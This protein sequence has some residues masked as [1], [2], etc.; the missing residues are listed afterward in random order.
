MNNTNNHSN[1]C[2]IIIWK[3][4]GAI[5]Y[6]TWVLRAL[7]STRRGSS[8]AG[9][10]KTKTPQGSSHLGS[11]LHAQTRSQRFGGTAGRACLRRDV[12]GWRCLALPTHHAFRIIK[13][14]AKAKPKQRKIPACLLTAGDSGAL[15]VAAWCVFLCAGAMGAPGMLSMAPFF[16]DG[17]NHPSHD[18]FLAPFFAH[19]RPRRPLPP[20]LRQSDR[21]SK[22][23]HNATQRQKQ[24]WMRD[25]RRRAGHYSCLM[26]RAVK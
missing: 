24:V 12:V 4:Y 3:I 16:G 25:R 13:N 18:F 17:P 20:S 22:I 10:S 7:N 5:D 23:D 15:F 19:P 14:Q 1:A 8:H 6:A 2:V 21:R 11:K 9:R 26:C